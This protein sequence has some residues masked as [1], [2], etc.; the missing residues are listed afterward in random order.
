MISKDTQRFDLKTG[1]PHMCTMVSGFSMSS[2][3]LV[4]AACLL[5][6]LRAPDSGSHCFGSVFEMVNIESGQY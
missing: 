3:L 2:A 6:P 1:G 5:T 4:T